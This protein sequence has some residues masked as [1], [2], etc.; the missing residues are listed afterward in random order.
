LTQSRTAYPGCEHDWLD[1]LHPLLFG[2]LRRA[3][4]FH[5]ERTAEARQDWL[6]VFVPVIR[7]AV[8][9]F[10]GDGARMGEVGRVRRGGI[11]PGELVV[12]QEAVDM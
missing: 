8:A 1:P 11:F 2:C 12:G 7:G 10:D 6:P 4:H 9:G 5:A 3:R